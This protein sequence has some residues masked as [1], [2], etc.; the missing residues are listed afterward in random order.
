MLIVCYNSAEKEGIFKVAAKLP[1]AA[2]ARN[3]CARFCVTAIGPATALTPP[4][5]KI[6]DTG[7]A[8]IVVFKNT[9]V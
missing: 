9:V 3:A 4:D 5:Q 8:R 7:V 2:A 6:P 1:K